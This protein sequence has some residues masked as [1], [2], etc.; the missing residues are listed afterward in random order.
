MTTAPPNPPKPRRRWLRFG[1][2]HAA[3]LRGLTQLQ[4][5]VP[6]QHPG[7]RR[8]T[9]ASPGTDATRMTVPRQHPG[10]RRRAG[11]SPG[12]DATPMAVPR[13]H[14][15]HRR[16][17]RRT[18]EG[19]AE[20]QDHS[21]TTAPTT[22]PKPR[23]RWL[24]FSLRTL[25]VL[26]LVLGCGL[27]WFASSSNRRGSSGKRSRRLRN[28]EA[29]VGSWPGSP[30]DGLPA[31]KCYGRPRWVGSRK[32]GQ[33]RRTRASPGLSD[34]R[35]R[36]IPRHTQVTDAGLARLR[37]LTQLEELFLDS[38]QVT[39]AGLEHLRGLTQLRTA[40]PPQHPGHRRGRRRTPEGIAELARSFDDHRTDHHPEAPPPLAAVQPA[41]DAGAGAGDV[42]GTELV[43]AEGQ[44]GRRAA[45]GRGSNP[46]T[47]WYR[48]LRLSARLDSPGSTTDIHTDRSADASPVRMAPRTAPR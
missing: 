32:H 19:I 23:R 42:R 35:S 29:R 33:R 25:M 1:L 17:C 10:H 11:A 27:G 21:M 44:T 18:P 22:T 4:Y 36:L 14:P 39:D 8:R 37:G 34:V 9:G 30:S 5:A 15:G 47:R 6:R 43:G 20:L 16:R 3:H 13:Q 24:Q 26:M 41:D 48:L 7:H 31:R 38:T 45:Q 2:P 12:T 40:G 46:Q 28:W